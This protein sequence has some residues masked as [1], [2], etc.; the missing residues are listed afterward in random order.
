MDLDRFRLA[1]EAKDLTAMAAALA[2]D[3]VFY[4]P[5]RQRPYRGRDEVARLFAALMEV[6]VDFH[7][8]DELAGPA[9]HGRLEP[10]TREASQALVF[11]ARIG[12]KP[13]DGVDLLR[14]D[15]HGNVV[16]FSVLVRPLPAAV[17]LARM[18]SARMGTDIGWPAASASDASETVGH[19]PAAAAVR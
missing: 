12:E 14:I 11:R 6:F 2:P 4:S 10:A 9:R 7:Y 8:V 18:V 17:V 3:V 1:V 13:L 15:E 16:E 5:V 19:S